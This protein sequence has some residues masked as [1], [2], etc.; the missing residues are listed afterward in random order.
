MFQWKNTSYSAQPSWSVLL[1]QALGFHRQGKLQEARKTYE[2]VLKLKVDS[3]DALHFLGV[4]EDAIGSHVKAVDLISKA[5]EISPRNPSSHLNL[6]NAFGN[7]QKFD[8]AIE[9][10]SRALEIKP[11]YVLALLNRGASFER[12]GQFDK[13]L[14][15]YDQAIAIAPEFSEAHWNKASIH[16]LRGDLL[17]GWELYEWRWRVS[18]HGM[19]PRPFSQPRWSGEPINGKKILIYDEQGLGDT[20]QF[21]R[22]VTKLSDLGAHTILDVSSSLRTLFK[23]LQGVGEFLDKGAVLPEFDFHSPIAS[24]PGLFKTE[25]DTIPC[26]QAYLSADPERTL[27]WA[28]RLGKSDRPRVGLVWSGNSA[29]MNDKNRSISLSEILPHMPPMNEYVSLQREIRETD[30][31]ALRTC[32]RIRH[33]GVEIADFADTAALC[34][35]MDVVV[36][37]DTSVAHLSGALGKKTLVLLPQLPDW[38]WLLGRENSP[39]Y[40]SIVLYRQQYANDWGSVFTRLEEYLRSLP[41]VPA[42]TESP[43]NE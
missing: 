23:T 21:A 38:R 22:Y 4:I 34:D 15:S 3:A 2:N 8:F 12:L 27:K 26:A 25:L 29:H 40:P 1:Q 14:E 9:S 35:L 10:Y 20:I 37:V 39:W 24:L 42:G 16:L 28:R 30:C 36:T 7:L 11:D 18:A 43:V 19:A 5:I 41:H 32:N 17:T 13:A 31:D 33:F 6:G